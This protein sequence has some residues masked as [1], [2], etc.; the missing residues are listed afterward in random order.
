MRNC[1]LFGVA[2]AART[3]LNAHESFSIMSKWV[4]KTAL[5]RAISWL[6]QSHKFNALFQQ[7][8]TKG[9]HVK[10]ASFETKVD[11]CRM[12]FE[13]YRKF[14]ANPSQSIKV[15]ELGTGWWP[16]IPVG[17]YLCGVEEIWTYDIAPLLRRD[18]FA[19]ILQFF[20]AYEQDGRL[21]KMLPA[22]R[23]ERLAQLAGLLARAE[24]EDP[25]ALLESLNIHPMVRDARHTE[26]PAGSIDL[27][28]SNF[29]L[30]HIPASVQAELYAE[31]KRVSGHD[32]VMSHYIG[33]G[34]QYAN[35][36]DSISMFNYMKY[37]S[38]QWR[39]LNNPIIPQTRL[40]AG[41]YRNVIESSGFTVFLQRNINGAK[42]DLQKIKLAPEF[43][44]YSEQDLLANFAWLVAGPR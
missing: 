5:Q 37:T 9:L 27:V 34:D 15:V 6:P 12:H 43:Q 17:L 29:C 2:F 23:P 1:Y 39:F 21:Q 36:D 35:F 8:V 10:P 14:S 41:D 20:V 19:R 32:S 13:H 24:R 3:R 44:H 42:E 11:N 38:K 22:A 4:F 33:I 26:L 31:F 28:Y 7:Y 18:T 40:R 30:E 25:K 16:I